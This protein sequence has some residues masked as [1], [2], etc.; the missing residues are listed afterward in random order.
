MI[1]DDTAPDVL[2]YE[3]YKVLG[4]Q[5]L[6]YTEIRIP[7]KGIQIF[8]E[9]AAEFIETAMKYCKSDTYVGIN[10]RK[11][12]NGLT[13]DVAYV[14]C[15]V[16][17]FDPIR[18]K[19]QPTTDAQ[20]QEAI[21]V[22]SEMARANEGIIISSGSGAHVYLPINP[23]K[24]TD[25]N[26]TN[27]ALR[28]YAKTIQDK[29]N[30]P[31]IKVDSTFDL[32]RIIRCWGSFNTKSNRP[33]K[34]LSGAYNSGRKTFRISE[35]ESKVSAPATP[36]KAVTQVAGPA[37]PALGKVDTKFAS[38]ANSNPTIR[39]MMEGAATFPSRSESDFAFAA[40]LFRSGF[41]IPEVIYLLPRNPKGKARERNERDL[42]KEVNRVHDRI[43][44][45]LPKSQEMSE[46]DYLKDLD[47]RKPGIMTGFK[48]WDNMTAGLKGGR[49]YV[50]AG[51]PTDGKTTYLVQQ[52]MNVAAQGHRVAIF[53]TE[54]ART[55]IIDKMVSA[56]TGVNL[57]AF[58]FGNFDSEERIKVEAAA[59]EVMKLPIT[60]VENFSLTMDDV[61][62]HV[63][64][65]SPDYVIVDFLQCMRYN[66]PNSTSELAANVIGIKSICKKRNIP[67]TLASQLHRKPQDVEDSMADL[68]GTGK[69]EEEGD[70]VTFIRTVN[71][72]PY[73]CQSKASV[74][75]NKYGEPGIIK[76]DFW[77][78]TCTFTEKENI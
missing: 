46:G 40:A 43:K 5:N 72:E 12:K 26:A 18:P 2:L 38:A 6:G 77:R 30:T 60:I 47:N 21:R 28:N 22:A 37:Q 25:A 3:Q 41:T 45:T 13:E 34:F 20:H 71:A 51:R 76:L 53:P 35:Y 78:S 10:P 65:I 66:D 31:E 75:K 59:K 63:E 64:N 36:Q 14:T 52:A 17:D 57:R 68:K 61:N 70:V 23:I 4:H 48:R 39:R 42:F 15:I 62:R 7:K 49:F 74:L 8:T 54:C 32:P 19:D 44:D 9:S 58:Q 24:V 27:E 69:L 11:I 55:T 56:K 67:V 33:C 16:F 29:Y 1:D 50:C 73:P